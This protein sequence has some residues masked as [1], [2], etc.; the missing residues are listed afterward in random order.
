M[1]QCEVWL[2]DLNPTRGA[3]IQKIRPCIIVNDDGVGKLPLRVVIPITDWKNHFAPISW[4]IKLDPLPTNGLQKM[5]TADCFQ[6]RSVSHDRFIRKIG[7]ITK[8]D[9]E[10]IQ[11]GL[12]VLFSFTS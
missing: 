7:T 4:L 11:K 6:T 9:F 5:S 2:V 1:N 3:E 12:A 10:R 8:T